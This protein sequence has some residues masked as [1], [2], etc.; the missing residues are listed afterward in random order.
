M[1]DL[2][3][4]VGVSRRNTA[5]I[6]AKALERLK[7]LKTGGAASRSA[8]SSDPSCATIVAAAVAGNPRGERGGLSRSGEGG[9]CLDHSADAN[10][11]FLTNITHS[12]T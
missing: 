9:K 8:D 7:A 10:R 5:K 1:E 12:M 6:R 11:V 3:E 2:E 4:A